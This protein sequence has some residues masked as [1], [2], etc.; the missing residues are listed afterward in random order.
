MK[1]KTR[2]INFSCFICRGSG[3]EMRGDVIAE[4]SSC[5]GMCGYWITDNDVL[6]QYPGGPF[7]GRWKRKFQ[8]LVEQGHE[9]RTTTQINTC[10]HGV[11]AREQ[12]C[13]DCK[14]IWDESTLER[15]SCHG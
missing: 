5:K 13:E 14:M 8:T 10:Q 9:P 11:D 1:K 4:C 12:E 3:H 6:A 15:Y 7:M 2:W